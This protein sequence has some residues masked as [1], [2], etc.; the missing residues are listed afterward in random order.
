MAK[1]EKLLTIPEVANYLR[2]N[3]FTIYRMA[4]RGDL[5]AIKVADLWRFKESDIKKW[6]EKNKQPNIKSKKKGR[7]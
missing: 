1:L 5:P 3:R 2:V 6:L 7:R 4:N